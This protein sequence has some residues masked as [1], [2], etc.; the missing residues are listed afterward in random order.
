MLNARQQKFIN[1]VSIKSALMDTMETLPELENSYTFTD[2]IFLQSDVIKMKSDLEK[3]LHFI[4]NQINIMKAEFTQAE[5]KQL[6]ANYK[7]A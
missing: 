2:Y 6:Y 3:Q 5:L 4:Q 1:L 7:K